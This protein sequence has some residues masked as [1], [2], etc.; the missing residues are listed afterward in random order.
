[1]IFEIGAHDGKWTLQNISID[2]D[3]I[4]A[5][6]SCKFYYDKL[7]KNCKNS[8]NVIA[9]NCHVLNAMTFHEDNDDWLV[10]S[11]TSQ[12]TITI[13]QLVKTYG[14]PSLIKV[15]VKTN[16][17]ACVSS[18]TSKVDMF[19]FEWTYDDVQ[20]VNV[21]IDYLLTLGFDE[22]S[23][24]YGNRYT[25]RPKAFVNVNVVKFKLL[26]SKF[27]EWGILWCK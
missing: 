21:C 27:N 22:F 2:G 19:C 20:L 11:K 10:C 25:Y 24:Q 17:Y 16:Q 5:I 4:I 15:N 3:K 23:I 13:D 18:L 12:Q 1:M 7:V 8:N 14:K 9:I 6:E 26:S